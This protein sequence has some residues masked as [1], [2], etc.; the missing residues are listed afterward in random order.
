MDFVANK[1]LIEGLK[2]E[3]LEEYILE[4][5]ILLLMVDGTENRGK[6]LMS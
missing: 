5:F 4:I 6:S 2:K 1:T 3:H